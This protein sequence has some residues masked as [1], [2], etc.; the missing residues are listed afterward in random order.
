MLQ[1]RITDV[2][3]VSFITTIIINI[4][5]IYHACK[6][7]MSIEDVVSTFKTDIICI[8]EVK[9]ITNIADCI[10]HIW[11]NVMSVKDVVGITY[12]TDVKCIT[13]VKDVTFT[14]DIMNI[15]YINIVK[16]IKMSYVA[17]KYAADFKGITEV[18]DIHI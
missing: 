17:G 3:D 13:D 14:T 10:F 1:V 4:H 6:Y 7:V 12:I 5:D 9:D 11:Q 15:T 8:T 18:T 16:Q 2:K